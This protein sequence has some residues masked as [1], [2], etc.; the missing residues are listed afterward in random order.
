MNGV[1][2]FLLQKKQTE[3]L[4]IALNLLTVSYANQ[5]SPVNICFIIICFII[6]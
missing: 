5:V 3:I 6:N 4:Y 2:S 1:W